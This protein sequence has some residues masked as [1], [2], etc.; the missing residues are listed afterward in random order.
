[1][2]PIV[3]SKSFIYEQLSSDV[4][5]ATSEF[6]KAY[7]IENAPILKTFG[8]DTVTDR[9]PFGAESLFP[10]MGFTLNLA[11][12]YFEGSDPIRFP[13]SD[14]ETGNYT[15]QPVQRYLKIAWGYSTDNKALVAQKGKDNA[16]AV[17]S[18]Q[19][20][21]SG[22]SLFDI[23]TSTQVFDLLLLGLKYIM[24]LNT[25]AA[26]AL[27][28][29]HASVES[30]LDPF[31]TALPVDGYIGDELKKTANADK[32][33]LLAD[34]A[35]AFTELMVE[36]AAVQPS[37]RMAE[38]ERKDIITGKTKKTQSQKETLFSDWR[39][40][41]F[42]DNVK[43]AAARGVRYAGMGNAHLKYL[44]PLGYDKDPYHPF[45]MTST[46]VEMLAFVANTDKLKKLAKP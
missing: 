8:V 30:K 40:F 16:A 25:A 28:T 44:K 34:F 23:V 12:P 39:N 22:S 27:A 42:E 3:G 17:K 32:P 2:L 20:I 41:M 43:A 26:E 21:V 38:P 15:G 29:V 33:P 7:E 24:T 19:T 46:G 9:Q 13:M 18:M 11:I 35:K 45:D 10:K 37:S 31:I 14:L 4:M 1:V 5:E 6:S 36:M